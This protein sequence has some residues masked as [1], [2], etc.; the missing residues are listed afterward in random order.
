VID[1]LQEKKF[2]YGITDLVTDDE[3]RFMCAGDTKGNLAIWGLKSDGPKL[4][5][6]LEEPSGY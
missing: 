3:S 1:Q 5:Y 4:M 6:I 2:N